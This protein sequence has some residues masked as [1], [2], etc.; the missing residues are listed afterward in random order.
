[1]NQERSLDRQEATSEPFCYVIDYVTS[2]DRTSHEAWLYEWVLDSLEIDDVAEIE[3]SRGDDD[4]FEVTL[5][6]ET[7][8]AHGLVALDARYRDQIEKLADRVDDLSVRCS[9]VDPAAPVLR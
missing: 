9:E 4:P 3:L 8:S 1:M 6:I 5:R 7:R 2:E